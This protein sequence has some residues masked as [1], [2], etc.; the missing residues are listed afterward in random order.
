MKH[1][2][3]RGFALILAALLVVGSLPMSFGTT[4]VKA[5]TVNLNA[6]DLSEGTITANKE[7]NG[8][9][10]TPNIA[11][12]A[13]VKTIESGIECTKRIKLGGAGSISSRSV[14]IKP[15]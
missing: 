9:T 12:D 2:I 7:V 11:I 3:K 4:T 1:R 8:F 5:A 15:T 13:S 10:L 6:S 14:I